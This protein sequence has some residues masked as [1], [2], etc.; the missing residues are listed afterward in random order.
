MNCI[1]TQL[2]QIRIF[3][4]NYLISG[5]VFQYFI[6]LEIFHLNILSS[7]VFVSSVI[8][9]ILNGCL[10]V[11]FIFSHF[12]ISL[13]FCLFHNP[14]YFLVCVARTWGFGAFFCTTCG[15]TSLCLCSEIVPRGVSWLTRS[16]GLCV[17]G[18]SIT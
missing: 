14:F 7:R 2:R 16:W 9:A 18:L 4:Q 6:S 10:K 12:C 13:K 5:I 8:E 15:S 11:S 1:F 17:Y 3:I